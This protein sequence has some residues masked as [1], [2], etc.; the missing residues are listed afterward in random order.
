[1]KTR[2]DYMAKKCSH[3]EY[4]GQFVTEAI[5]SMVLSMF[6]LEELL[7][8]KDE[9]LNDLPLARWD[10]LAGGMGSTLKARALREAGDTPRWGVLSAY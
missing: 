1:M 5:R 8:S 7:N 4:C 9:H 3:R 2:A 10:R 6:T